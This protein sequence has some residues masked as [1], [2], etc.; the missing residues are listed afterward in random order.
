MPVRRAWN[1]RLTRCLAPV[2]LLTPQLM[3]AAGLR[4]TKAAAATYCGLRFASRAI[5]PKIEAHSAYRLRSSA[6]VLPRGVE[7]ALA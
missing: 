4:L 5:L 2:R 3:D 7:A 1:W 6:G